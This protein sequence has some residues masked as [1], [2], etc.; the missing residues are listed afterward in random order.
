MNDSQKTALCVPVEAQLQAYNNR[1]IEAYLACF[2]SDCVVENATGEVMMAGRD[3]MKAAYS[4]IFADC[5]SLHATIVNRAIVSGKMGDY[6][7][8]EERVVGRQGPDSDAVTHA[9]AIYR[10]ENQ[11]ISHIRFIS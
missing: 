11:L 5:P 4:K 2:S 7:L 3:Q 9:V 6:V 8:D 1:D 10:I